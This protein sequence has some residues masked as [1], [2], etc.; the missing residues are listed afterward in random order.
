DVRCRCAKWE[1]DDRTYLHAA[2][3]KQTLRQ[4]NPGWIDT[5]RRKLELPGLAAQVLDVRSLRVGLEQ[6]VIDERGDARGC[7]TGCV[8]THTRGAG[9]EHAAQPVGTTIVEYRVTGTSSMRARLLRREELGD[10]QVDQP[11][12]FVSGHS[13]SRSLIFD[14]RRI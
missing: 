1:T 4:S 2:P 11:F 8:D 3:A 9:I 6:R 13:R 5:H 7:P 14:K 12:D 10:D